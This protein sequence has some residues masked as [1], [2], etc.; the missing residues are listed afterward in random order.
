[1]EG[2]KAMTP[3]ELLLLLEHPIATAAKAAAA[4][5]DTVF[6]FRFIVSCLAA[7]EDTCSDRSLPCTSRPL[8]SA[9]R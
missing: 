5:G 7:L 8:L 6:V 3:P 2:E 9:A 1:V 4:T